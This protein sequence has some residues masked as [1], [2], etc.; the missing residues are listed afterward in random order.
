MESK[1]PSPLI[2]SFPRFGSAFVPLGRC[3]QTPLCPRVLPLLPLRE[4]GIDRFP[5]LRRRRRQLLPLLS[6]PYAVLS[7]LLVVAFKATHSATPGTMRVI[8]YVWKCTECHSRCDIALN[9]PRS[10]SLHAVFVR[11][12][13]HECSFAGEMTSLDPSITIFNSGF[14]V[15]HN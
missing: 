7:S 9:C 5:P 4:E 6:S 12:M 1:L 11:R 2:H 10:R 8:T 14:A 3:L 13:T 15:T